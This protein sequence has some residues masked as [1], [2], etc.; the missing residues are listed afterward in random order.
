MI[1]ADPRVVILIGFLLVLAGF[2]LPFLMVMRII[3]SSFLLNLISYG[4]SMAGLIMG[5]MGAAMWTRIERARRRRGRW[6]DDWD[7][8]WE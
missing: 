7:D 1:R 2:V 4:A 6:D 5:L 3:A 8:D